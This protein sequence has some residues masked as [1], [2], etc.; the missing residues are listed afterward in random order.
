MFRK[1]Q[2]LSEHFLLSE[3]TRSAKADELKIDN[4][5]PTEL[6]IIRME[7]LCD[8]V[9][10]PLRRGFDGK[11]VTILSGWRCPELNKAVGGAEDSQHMK[12]EA[13]D[14]TI[15]GVPN[16]WVFNFIQKNLS[17]DQLIAE[18]LKEA[19][20]AAGWVHVSFR[21]HKQRREVLSYL[22]EGE[23]VPGLRFV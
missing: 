6:Q 14:I 22:G 16:V 20:G 18:R 1:P 7:A 9:L 21:Y 13:A 15:A 8:N 11:P 19:D 10:E 23:Y 5:K 2:R 17:F 3:F 12:G 4:T